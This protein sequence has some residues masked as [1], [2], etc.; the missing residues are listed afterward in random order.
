MGLIASFTGHHLP[1][2]DG[3][4]SNADL[5]PVRYQTGGL[6]EEHLTFFIYRRNV[7]MTTIETVALQVLQSLV[8]VTR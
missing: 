3:M 4:K 8:R 2:S 7:F 6:Y 5:L 1:N